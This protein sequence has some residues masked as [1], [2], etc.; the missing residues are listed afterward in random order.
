VDRV[1]SLYQGGTSMKDAARQVAGET[2]FQKKELYR[3]AVQE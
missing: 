1:R 2:G 3:L